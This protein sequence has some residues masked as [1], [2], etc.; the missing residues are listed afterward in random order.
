M[1]IIE[2]STV[3]DAIIVGAGI[4]G[5]TIASVIKE[6]G[7]ALVILEARSTIG[8]VWRSY[9]NPHSRVNSSEPA[10]RMRVQRE[11]PNTEH[12]HFFEVID[13]LR[14]NMFEHQH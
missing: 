12:S 8:G 1:Q 9:G 11:Q 5:L 7:L 6:A 10:Y 2:N 3:Y 14:R 4:T 13:D